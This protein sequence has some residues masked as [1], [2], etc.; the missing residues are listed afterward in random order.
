M[1]TNQLVQMAILENQAF[2]LMSRLHV[3]MRRQLNRVTDI[4]YM[5]INPD[6]CRYLIDLAMQSEN[7]DMHGIGSK[8]QEL[9][10]GENGLFVITPPK[11]PLIERRKN[12]A[13]TMPNS[14]SPPVGAAPMKVK[15][16]P[17]KAHAAEN[18]MEVNRAYVGSLR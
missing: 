17:E 1:S 8:L 7:D 9:Y 15:P 13:A 4:E 5:R 3:T 10:F 2:A 16:Q 6:Y 14:V 12:V 18:A 11:P